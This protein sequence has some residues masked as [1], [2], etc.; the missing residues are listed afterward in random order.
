[1]LVL[2]LPQYL[3]S[4]GQSQTGYTVMQVKNITCML[5]GAMTDLHCYKCDPNLAPFI[6]YC[7][8]DHLKFIFITHELKFTSSLCLSLYQKLWRKKK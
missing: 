3:L 2:S 7:N 6:K 8:P 4:Q 5:T 1:M